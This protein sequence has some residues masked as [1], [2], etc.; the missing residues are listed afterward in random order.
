MAGITAILY[1]LLILVIAAVGVGYALWATPDGRDGQTR[2][3]SGLIAGVVVV[4]LLLM[5]G[6]LVF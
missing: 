1:S 4:Y 6:S 2:L 3:R 5:I